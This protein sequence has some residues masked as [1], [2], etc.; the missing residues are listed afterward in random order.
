[1]TKLKY[2]FFMPLVAPRFAK[3]TSTCVFGICSAVVMDVKMPLLK[4]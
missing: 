1:M 3:V 2:D 4:K